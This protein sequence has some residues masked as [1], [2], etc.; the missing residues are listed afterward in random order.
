[1]TLRVVDDVGAERM[2]TVA[3]AVGTPTA[4]EAMGVDVPGFGAG[5]ALAGL[6]GVTLEMVR[7]RR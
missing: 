7:R 5:A 1:M 2:T 6:A 4:T 3:L